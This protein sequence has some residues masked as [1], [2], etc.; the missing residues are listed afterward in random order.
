MTKKQI[1]SI[2]ILIFI[3]LS[4]V[5]SFGI[6][7]FSQKFSKII[8][9][10]QIK[11]HQ[12][13][14]ENLFSDQK[15]IELCYALKAGDLNKADEL[16]KQGVDINFK[17]KDGMTPFLWLF[18][19][20]GLRDENIM[21]KSFQWLVKHKADPTVIYAA[22]L[23]EGYHVRAHYT[24]F[25]IAAENS[26]IFYL[27]TLL[28]SGLIKD[29]D[30]ELPE[31]ANPTALLQAD[32][33]D[34]FENFKLLL[35][36]GADPNKIIKLAVDRPTLNIVE[37]NMSW[38]FAYELLKRGANFNTNMRDGK[39]EIV[40][41]IEDIVFVPSVSLNYRGVDYRQK[42]VEFLENH[43][44]KDIHPDMPDDEKYVKENGKYQLY[45]LEKEG[46]KAGQWVKFE[47]SSKYETP[48]T[49]EERKK[50]REEEDKYYEGLRYKR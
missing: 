24:V 23:K 11:Q 19:F 49:E 50:G 38:R 42:C 37:G 22:P 25:H 18:K 15:V 6:Y 21:K 34:R 20:S 16:L 17:G 31:N 39:S 36:Y 9:E 13:D 41:V 8:Q 3:L 1:W 47:E 27:K 7:R 48:L 4:G 45:I 28:K 35:D 33:S 32:L 43:G 40:R 10:N 44:V 29:I 26:N 2:I 14:P 46:D 5:V 30:L 12:Y